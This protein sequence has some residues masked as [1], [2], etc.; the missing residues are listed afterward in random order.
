MRNADTEVAAIEEGF[1]RVLISA[2]LRYF[3]DTDDQTKWGDDAPGR[4]KKNLAH[5][6]VARET[7]LKIIE[8]GQ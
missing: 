7:A 4:F 3:E 8:D 6:R 5:A 2:F 1:K